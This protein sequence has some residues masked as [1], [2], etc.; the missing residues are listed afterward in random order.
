MKRLC[1][2]AG[3]NK[4]G[5]VS[6]YVVYYVREMAKLADVYYLADCEIKQEELN[7]LAPYT[8]KALAFRHKKYDF[9]SWQE[10]IR[11][12]GRDKLAEYDELI[13]C[14]DSCFGPLYDMK[15]IFDRTAAD[16]DCDFW[17][18]SEGVFPE[19]HLQSYF[20]VFK[21]VV[22]TSDIFRKFI[23]GIKTQPSNLDVIRNY[24]T[25]IF[26]AAYRNR[27]QTESP[28]KHT[29]ALCI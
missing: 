4:K 27:V 17:G 11:K 19:P 20:M 2:F 13:L 5:L 12:I 1:L 14:N 25:K 21:K 16:K 29:F 24:R 10:M 23:N 18:L 15:P 3:Y 7:K 26:P 22:F 28:D 8:K 9:G 6:D